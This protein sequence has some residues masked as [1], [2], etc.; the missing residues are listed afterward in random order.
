[1]ARYAVVLG[2][3]DWVGGNVNQHSSAW[4]EHA[5]DFLQGLAVVVE[6][7]EHIE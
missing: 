4:R 7:F 6:V 3:Q 1:M 2:E 5:R